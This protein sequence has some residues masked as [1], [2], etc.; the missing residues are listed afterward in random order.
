MIIQSI[1]Q[2]I[3]R[4]VVR[5][6]FDSPL[7]NSS[8][9][10]ASL[11]KAGEQG[12][13]YDPSDLSTMF[14]DSAG[15]TPVTAAGQPVGLIRDKSGR[16]N[17]ASQATAASRPMLRN[18]GGLWWLEFDGAD[19]FLETSAINLTATNKLSGFFGLR[20]VSIVATSVFAEFSVSSGAN[21]GAFAVFAPAPTDPTLT[22][23][24]RC[25][26]NA[27]TLDNTS[28]ASFP[29]PLAAALS[30]L[31]D[32]SGTTSALRISGDQTNVSAAPSAANFGNYALYIGRRGGTTQPFAGNLYGFIVRGAMTDAS[33]ITNTEKFMG[34]KSGVTL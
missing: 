16:G 20:K 2:S 9:S 14:Q 34:A 27:A 1:V 18:S 5:S 24:S 31:M 13:W 15:A 33:G 23:G 10:P 11:F 32:F 19:D 7:I 26:S 28:N 22:F 25:R 30:I 21:N 17:H 6:V 3:T 29:S 4:P 12:A 8:Y